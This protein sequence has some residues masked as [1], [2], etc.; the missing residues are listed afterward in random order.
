MKI[1]KGKK[2]EDQYSHPYISGGDVLQLIASKDGDGEV[3]DYYLV[4]EGS[5]EL[6]LFNL[7]TGTLHTA[8]GVF[9][10]SMQYEKVDACITINHKD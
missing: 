7:K 6:R 5:Y 2:R 8:S 4:A 10:D 3:G 9:R 1:C